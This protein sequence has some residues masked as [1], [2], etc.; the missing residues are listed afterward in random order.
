MPCREGGG[1]RRLR[2]AAKGRRHGDRRPG[3]KAA[4]NANA[5]PWLATAGAGDVLTGMIAGLMAPGMTAFEA[6]PLRRLAA[7][8]CRRA[9]LAPA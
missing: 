4:I 9:G 3:S 2:C 5:P 1:A 7:R 6:A 8:R